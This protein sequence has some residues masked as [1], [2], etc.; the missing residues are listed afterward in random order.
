MEDVSPRSSAVFGAD[1]KESGDRLEVSKPGRSRSRQPAPPKGEPIVTHGWTLTT[2]CGFREVCEAI[3][4][5]AFEDNDLPIIISLEIHTDTEQQ[6]IMV[7]IMKEV[8]Q[9]MLMEQPLEGCDPKF[10]VPNLEDLRRK[11]LIKVKR[12]PASIVAPVTMAVPSVQLAIEEE[13]SDSEEAEDQAGLAATKS[14]PLPKGPNAPQQQKSSKV[15]ICS[16]LSS[17]AVYTRSERFEGFDKPQA[18]RKTHIFSISEKKILELHQKQHR[19]MFVHNKSYFMRAFP[20]G[21]RIDSS[22]PDPSPF[23]RKGVQMVAM[24]WQ[25]LDEGMMVNEAMFADEQGYVLKPPGYQSGV[26]AGETQDEA[27]PGGI[28]DLTITVFAGQH[29]PRQNRDD[30]TNTRSGSTIRPLIKAELHVER[31]DATVKD[32]QLQESS[33]KQRTETARTDHPNFGPKGATLQFL[34]IHKV[35]QEM[36]FIRLVAITP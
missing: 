4:D 33:Y 30:E 34:N 35:V 7:K 16:E 27:A 31:P 22:N 26:K 36:S 23:W 17:L 3:R 32:G 10:R 2:P 12:A 14:E 21:R 5:S 29:I 15:P 13:A 11:I 24:N 28:L 25:N 8:W 18:N 6:K 9:D 1:P 20:A 19:D